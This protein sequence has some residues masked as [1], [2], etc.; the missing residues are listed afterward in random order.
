MHVCFD[1]PGTQRQAVIEH[2]LPILEAKL[3][4]LNIEHDQQSLQEIVGI[5]FPDLR[6]IAELIEFKFC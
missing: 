2:W 1:I 5:Y 4:A 3:A 6:R